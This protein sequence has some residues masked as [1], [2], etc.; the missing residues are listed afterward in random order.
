MAISD[1]VG[2]MGDGTTSDMGIP[3]SARHL[4]TSTYDG[5]TDIEG[6]VPNFEEISPSADIDMTIS[7]ALPKTCMISVTLKTPGKDII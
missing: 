3:I 2:F 1:K 6:E 4:A 7:P 5:C